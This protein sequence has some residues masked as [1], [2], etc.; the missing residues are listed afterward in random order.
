MEKL[1]IRGGNSLSGSINCSGAKNAALPMIA[2]TILCDEKIILKNKRM[3][4]QFITNKNDNFYKNGDFENMLKLIIE[5]NSMCEIK[6][7]KNQSSEK[8]VVIFKEV[9]TIKKAI[10]KLQI[11]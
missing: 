7:K 5:N 8:L 10:E 4:C 9:N 2:S 6:E 1:L 11:F 3:I